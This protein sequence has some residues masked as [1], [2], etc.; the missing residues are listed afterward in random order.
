MSFSGGKREAINL[1]DQLIICRVTH[2][3]V[4]TQGW[5]VG[6]SEALPGKARRFSCLQPQSWSWK[7]N[8]GHLMELLERGTGELSTA[9]FQSWWGSGNQGWEQETSL[10]LA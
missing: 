3:S 8:L 9:R 1:L 10:G 2:G 5:H 7:T 6:P 4:G